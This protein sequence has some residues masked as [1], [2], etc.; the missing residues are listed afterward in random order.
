MDLI[1]EE[2]RRSLGL[3]RRIVQFA[4][5][6]A[7]VLCCIAVARLALGAL[8]VGENAELSRLGQKQQ[9][10]AQSQTR[11]D[12]YRQ[13]KQAIEQQ[14]AA[15]EQ[16]RRGERVALLLRAIDQAYGEGIWLDSIHFMRGR[17]TTRLD[18]LPG[19]ANAGIIV[20]PD[21]PAGND[22]ADLAQGADIAGHALDHSVL[23]EFIRKLG[24]QPGVADLRLVS[25]GTRAYSVALVVD[26][27][28]A[29]QMDGKAAVRP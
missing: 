29:L 6:C 22:A 7:V 11:A 2:F 17:G 4:V 20:V 13:R 10:L 21:K 18:N 15:L 8:I 3:R 14:L 1:P 19:S 24:V 25:T 28:L 16:L 23:A 9:T 5:A 27:K 26:F 12:D